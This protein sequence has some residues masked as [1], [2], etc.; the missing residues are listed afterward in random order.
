MHMN[1]EILNDIYRKLDIICRIQL[2]NFITEMDKIQ[3][4][5]SM[6]DLGMTNAE[7]AEFLNVRP[8]V[9]TA[10]LSEAKKRKQK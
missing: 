8:N 6:S 4:T 2:S 1:D 3:A 9:I 5:K 7:I 10:R